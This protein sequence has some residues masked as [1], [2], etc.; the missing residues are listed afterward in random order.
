MK[1]EKT[2]AATLACAAALCGTAFGENAERYVGADDLA[3]ATCGFGLK[4]QAGKS[5]RGRPLTVAG[6]V[7][8]K[9]V[10]MHPEGAVGF[11]SDGGALAFDALVGIDD[12][13]NDFKTWKTRKA[14]ATFRVWADGKV[15]HS[16]S[17]VEG[18]KPVPV[19]VALEGAKE[20]V[21]EAKSCAP[22]IATEAAD[23]DV[24]DARFTLREGASLKAFDDPALVRQLGILTPPAPKAPQFNGANV[25]GVR[26]G[27]PVIFRVPI[28]GERPM[29]LAAAGLPEGVT[30]DAKKG[31]LGGVAP[32][33][34]GSYPVVVTA[35]NAHGEARRTITI[36]VG[37]T[38]CLTPP[39]GWNS[40]NIWGD[41]FTGEHAMAAAKAL[42]ESGLGDYGW[43]YINLDDFWEMNNSEQNKDRD[44]L[45]GPARDENGM[46]LSNK[47]FPDMKGM[48]DYIHSFGFKAGLYSSPGPLTC[49]GCEGSYG[50]EMQDAK[51]WADWGF[52]Y[53]K[54]D[55]CSYGE[56]FKKESGWGTWDYMGKY[57]AGVPDAELPRPRPTTDMWAKPYRL[58][59]ECL[60]A[61]D[62]DIVYSFCQYGCGK[63]EVWGREAGANCWRSWQD[64]KD[65][66]TWMEIAIEGYV[67][68]AE[69]WKY[70][71]P[72]FWSDPDMMIV[73]LQ[74]S[75]GTTHPTYLT[76]N[77]QYTHVSLWSMM[78]S[79]L[80]IGTDLTQLDPFTKSLLTNGMVIDV[81]Q[82]PLGTPARRIRHVDAESVWTRPLSGGDIA[83]ALVNRYPFARE[84]TVDFSDLGTGGEWWVRDLWTQKCEGKH[85]DSIMFDVPAHG[86]KLVRMKRVPC[87]RCD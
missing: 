76:P 56:I 87:P 33:A 60:K 11:T 73:G 46:I 15:V 24:L 64:L 35:K 26:P 61:Q 47:S 59:G 57:Q 55:W 49:G 71:G 28:S 14:K 10:G 31:I 83:V 43:A 68:N 75:F 52:D 39:M 27:R 5:V 38:I 18:Q 17:V 85:V 16:V 40:W 4:V 30:F 81:C 6:R 42:D 34:P 19:H 37:D 45:R 25:W 32:K 50:H 70:T 53:V 78:C 8:E 66:W 74:R 22:W 80:L 48:T 69:H 13:C 21:L 54:Y 12:G 1:M 62:R 41:K 44:E 79:P 77:E 86:V 82:D 3:V 67:K 20:I 65:G 63:V 29:E 51:R 7:F 9:G 2:I 36:K 72:G 58:M 23:L 84:I